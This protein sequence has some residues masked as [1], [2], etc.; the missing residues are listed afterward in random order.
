MSDEPWNL[1]IIDRLPVRIKRG[2]GSADAD[3]RLFTMHRAERLLT[4]A[5]YGSI[6]HEALEAFA[7]TDPDE[8]VRE[9]AAEILRN[10]PAP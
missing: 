6:V 7:R 1:P 10:A 2:L 9:R 4:D 8:R 5:E 3:M